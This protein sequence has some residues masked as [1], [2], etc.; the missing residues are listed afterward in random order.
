MIYKCIKRI[1]K[2]CLEKECGIFD[3]KG[4]SRETFDKWMKDGIYCSIYTRPKLLRIL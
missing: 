4:Y 3:E 2:T 1:D